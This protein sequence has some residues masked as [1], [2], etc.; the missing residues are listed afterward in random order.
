MKQQRIKVITNETIDLVALSKVIWAK[1][2]FIVLIVLN[3]G[4]FGI[5]FAFI[6][7]NYYQSSSVFVPSSQSNSLTND[8]GGLAELAGLSL[9]GSLAQNDENIP[10]NLY[11]R[12]ISSNDFRYKLINKKLYISSIQDS[13]SYIDYYETLVK[14]SFLGNVVDFTFGLPRKAVVALG[15][16]VNANKTSHSDLIPKV[17]EKRGAD[18]LSFS[19]R[20]KLNMER[21][22]SQMELKIDQKAGFITL[23]FQ[24][25]DPFLAAQ[26]ANNAKEQLQT[27]IKKIQ[28][29]KASDH[30]LFLTTELE[31]KRNE[32]EEIQQKLAEFKDNNL[33]I[34]SAVFANELVRLESEYNI[35]YNVYSM[36]ANQH[37]Q[38]K[39]QVSRDTPIFTVIQ[40]VSIPN[41]KQGPFR[42]GII[43][44]YIL[45]GTVVAFV[46]LFLR[47]LWSV[48]RER[49]MLLTDTINN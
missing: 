43:A 40:S 4:L 15:R 24:M 47:T 49:W 44:I 11:P 13:I 19:E 10:P 28:N 2:K 16:I 12:L 34:S 31:K 25:N 3:F 39:I 14:S 6:S 22:A 33:N 7:P 29:Q 35:S 41:E 26:M 36:L 38:A 27:E 21:L 5:L 42:L 37:A 32:F 23:S 46:L 48:F 8:F 1:R 20:E 9:G 17:F 30:L 18:I 45:V